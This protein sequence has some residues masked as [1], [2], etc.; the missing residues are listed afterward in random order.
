MS[1]CRENKNIWWYL[2]GV[3]K[4]YGGTKN[5]WR[6]WALFHLRWWRSEYVFHDSIGKYW[7]RLFVC[8]KHNHIE[9]KLVSDY[10]EPIRYHCFKCERDV[11]HEL[12]R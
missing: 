6:G 2:F 10:G 8:S 4:N 9:V 11:T 7:N 12:N 1:A 5:R 3:W